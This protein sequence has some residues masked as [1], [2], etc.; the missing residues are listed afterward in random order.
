MKKLVLFTFIFMLFILCGCDSSITITFDSNGGSS[1][2][3]ITLEESGTIEKPSDP[4]KDG[5]YFSGWYLNDTLFDFSTV[6]SKSIKLK[7]K[8][9]A[10][11][12]IYFSGSG[13]EDFSMMFPIGEEASLPSVTRD[14]YRFISW[15]D[16]NEN[17]YTDSA[18]FN[19]SHF[20]EVN[21]QKIEVYNLVY[22]DGDSI[23]KN[24]SVVE[25]EKVE[26]FTPEKEGYTFRGWYTNTNYTKEFDFENLNRSNAV[27][28]WFEANEYT[29]S[30][31]TFDSSKSIK[32]KF[33]SEYG[34]FPTISITNAT[35]IGW[36]YN[37]KRVFESDIYKYSKDIELYPILYLSTKFYVTENNIQTVVYKM[38]STGPYAN[39]EKIGYV[40][41]G[42]YETSDLSGN[43]IECIDT[44]KYANK[45][46]YAKF[47][48]AVDATDEVDKVI[49]KIIDYYMETLDGKTIYRDLPLLSTDPFYGA[50]IEWI[51]DNPQV[52]NNGVVT[53]TRENVNVSLTSKITYNNK[54]ATGSYNIVLKEDIYKDIS[55]SVIT[56]YCYTANM[57]RRGVDEILLETADV[58]NLAFAEA[59][60][61]GELV[62]TVSYV[63]AYEKFKQ[64]ARDAGVRVIITVGP[65][66][67]PTI[68]ESI[69][70]SSA[71][72]KKFARNIVEAINKY[73]FAGVDIDWEYPTS[74]SRTNYTALMKD[75][76]EQ[77]KENNP[78]DLVTSAIPAGPYTFPNFDLKNSH[79]YLDF[80]NLMSYDMQASNVTSH[81]AAL[82]PNSGAGTVSGCSIEETVKNF[83]GKSI[84]VPL[85]KIVIGAAFYGR[86]I[87]TKKISGTKYLYVQASSDSQW[88]SIT[89]SGIKNNYLTLSTCQ[90]YWD[91]KAYAAYCYDTASNKFITYDNPRSLEAKCDY[92]VSKGV[93][94]IMWWDYGSDSTGELIAAINSKLSILK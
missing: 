40:F 58:I 2:D 87:E 30:F 54:T 12:E 78:E 88:V 15:V 80:I 9:V 69:A 28:A 71:L 91:S 5:F 53:R 82:Y 7:A 47:V 62:L 24:V 85:N 90:E 35:F 11:V 73:G 50:S 52:K 13:I 56:S 3:K 18:S 63:N 26:P 21:W 43:K 46:V 20:L 16:E 75:I 34:A 36:E 77:V 6:I 92:V 10:G 37:G 49:N 25:G 64:A 14:G 1:V 68:F 55:K 65:P 93:A 60:A 76:Y 59:K 86:M 41:D 61:D 72:R 70:S 17:E 51:S 31:A 33:D 83:T 32:V 57:G 19:E 67:D 44:A 27:Y 74:A 22:K 79:Q 42:W 94:G 45:T 23:I 66:S 84:G 38:G 81:H 89:Y 8:W 39:V 29:V 48:P 4:T